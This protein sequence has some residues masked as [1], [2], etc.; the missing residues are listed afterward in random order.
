MKLT[1]EHGGCW[2]CQTDEE[3]KDWLS[4]CEFDCLLH[5]HCLE[6]EFNEQTGDRTELEI[7][8]AEFE[9]YFEN[10]KHFPTINYEGKRVLTMNNERTEYRNI[11]VFCRLLIEPNEI[12]K[13]SGRQSSKS[14]YHSG[15]SD[16]GGVT[17]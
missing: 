4:S 16:I 11:C 2:Y 10:C 15:P 13:T 14:S 5:A 7:F 12:I 3:T 8:A 9:Y 1:P 17:F 6:K